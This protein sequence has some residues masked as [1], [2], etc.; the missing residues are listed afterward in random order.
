MESTRRARKREGDEQ[1]GEGRS[2]MGDG[3]VHDTLGVER[4]RDGGVRWGSRG[5]SRGK[6]TLAMTMHNA[7]FEC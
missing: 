3:E 4:G 2:K 7:A 6:E 5:G 1:R